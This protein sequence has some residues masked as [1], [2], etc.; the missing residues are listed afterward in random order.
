M[1]QNPSLF[2]L[3]IDPSSKEHLAEAAKWAR[4]LAIIGFVFLGFLVVAGIAV[5]VTISRLSS[6]FSDPAF[7]NSG[8]SSAMGVGTAFVYLVMA[9]IYLFPLLYLLR[10]ANAA[11]TALTTNDQELLNDSFRNL[12]RFLRY[13]GILTII[14]LGFLVVSVVV[15]IAGLALVNR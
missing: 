8:F 13:L 7:R 5:S 9:I 3:S 11:R 6:G 4:F 2:S 12:K 1:E 10:F 15:S 14:G